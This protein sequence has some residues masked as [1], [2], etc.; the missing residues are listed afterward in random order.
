MKTAVVPV[1][2]IICVA[3]LPAWLVAPALS[4]DESGLSLGLLAGWLGMG[5]IAAS[6]LLMVRE[7]LW[8]SW[9]GGLQRMYQWHHAMGVAGYLLLLAHPLL[10]A[11]HYLQLDAE[12]AWEYLSPFNPQA[13]NSLGWA[14]LLIFTLGLAVTFVS[15]LPYG[16]WR[17]LHVS[18]AVAMGL[19]LGHAWFVSGFSNSLWMVVLLTIVSVGWRLLRADRGMGARPYE[20]SQVYHPAAHITETI[21]KPLAKPLL[22]APG[23]FVSAAFF[24]GPYFQGCGDFHPYTV[25]QVAEDGSLTLS[26]KALGACTQH[27]QSLQPGVAVRLQ[28]PYGTFLLNRPVASEVWIAAGIGLTP[29]LALLR[30]Q[31]VMQQT[32]LIYVHRESEHIPYQSELQRFAIEQKHLSFQS[33]TM[34]TDPS[35]LFAWL[36]KIDRLNEKQIY[37]CGPP[38]LMLKTTQ[39]LQQHGVPRQQI[40]FEQ[41]DFR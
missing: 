11:Y 24:E 26:I 20:V 8:A 17:R 18:L 21:L 29:F 12:I 33:L 6:L 41:F 4:M 39:W 37:L 3:L 27:I 40:H 23:Q 25:S 2:W 34:S 19:G 30:S 28:G 1:I 15:R 5:M 22:V 31:F 9:F 16:L 36:E 13:T 35:P 38:P 14:A 7:P 32:D 10:L